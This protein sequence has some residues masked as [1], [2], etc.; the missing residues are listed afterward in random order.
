MDADLDR[1]P[2]LAARLL[3]ALLAG[4]LVITLIWMSIAKLDISVHAV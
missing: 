3:V 1:G 4:F 2:H